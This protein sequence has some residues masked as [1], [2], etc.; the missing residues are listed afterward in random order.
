VFRWRVRARRNDDVWSAHRGRG[1]VVSVESK[2]RPGGDR[3]ARSVLLAD[4]IREGDGIALAPV[5]HAMFKAAVVGPADPEVTTGVF[6]LLGS[7]DAAR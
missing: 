2:L 7:G 4:V 6:R 5:L 3:K 1:D